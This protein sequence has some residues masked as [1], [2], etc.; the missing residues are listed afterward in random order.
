MKRLTTD[1]PKDNYSTALN[2]FYIKD[3]MTMVR[4]GGAAP[5][6][7]DVSL[8]EHMRRIIEAHGVDIPAES[9][10]E[11]DEIMAEML[12]DGPETQE[13]L[14]AAFYTAAWAFSALREQL[15]EYED[16]DE[17]GALV[18]LPCK[19]DDT[20]YE[21]DLPE[22]GAIT[23]KV[24]RVLAANQRYANATEGEIIRAVSVL[25]LVTEGHGEGSSYEFC[26]EDF[27]KTV[28][29]SREEAEAALKERFA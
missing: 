23:C 8:P 9:D 10:E 4:G 7:P 3:R 14:L 27:G 24:L 25:V 28:F 29:F 12:F 6:Y 17:Q 13:G 15:K 1:N 2:L 22:Y 16:A 19:V 18:M 11:L 21:I 26:E 5:D 20:L